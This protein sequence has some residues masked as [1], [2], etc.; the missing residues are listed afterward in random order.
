MMAGDLYLGWSSAGMATSKQGLE[1]G[2][3][4]TRAPKASGRAPWCMRAHYDAAPHRRANG[5]I[6]GPHLQFDIW[7]R[8]ISNSHH[9]GRIPMPIWR[10]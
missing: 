4:L 7:K 2:A 5:D 3:S 1:L 8:G 9:S 6:M 10:R